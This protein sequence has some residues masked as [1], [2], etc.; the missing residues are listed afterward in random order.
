MDI[1]KLG[2]WPIRVVWF[3]VL[4]V[5]WL[6]FAD[7][8]DAATGS[9]R[10]LSEVMLWAGWFV[11]LVCLL[12]PSTVSLTIFRI[13]APMSIGAPLLG[14]TLASTWTTGVLAGLA[15][16][17]PVT[18]LALSNQ[19]GDIMVNGSA[20]GPERRLALR[21]PASLLLGPIQL[22]WLA[23]V[24]GLVTGPLL[25]ANSNWISGS[26]A[27][28]IG[29]L[30][31]IQTAK[32]LHQ[33]SRR[34]IVYVPAGFVIH[35]FWVLA[36]SVLLRRNQIRALGPMALDVGNFLDLGAN[37]HGLSLMVQLDEKIPLALR[38]NKDIQTFSAHRLV[39]VPSLP[40][41]LLKEARVRGIKIGSDAET[42][43][44]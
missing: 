12:A 36:E 19:V 29:W 34:W 39:F 8:F 7:I 30:V 40:A 14:A 24:A 21:P 20:Y 28:V 44:E 31:A 18:V 23:C 11:G 2:L 32:S 37:S 9:V 1:A 42:L 10:N 17:L 16:G 3:V 4:G 26:I 22:A 41:T 5:S 38:A 13:V 6:T 33:L 15:V 43:S 35:D 27:L 25:L